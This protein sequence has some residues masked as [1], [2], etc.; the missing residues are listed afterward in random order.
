MDFQINVEL[1]N[2]SERVNLRKELRGYAV[3]VAFPF[4]IHHAI[5]ESLCHIA[6]ARNEGASIRL[7]LFWS[8]LFATLT[9]SLTC[10]SP[11]STLTLCIVQLHYRHKSFPKFGK[12]G[13]CKPRA[14]YSSVMKA[15]CAINPQ[16]A[17]G[18]QLP[19]NRKALGVRNVLPSSQLYI[20]QLCVTHPSPQGLNDR[21]FGEN[22]H[23]QNDGLFYF[24]L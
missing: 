21:K 12:L 19:P 7:S 4:C 8:L 2:I 5:V 18:D 22:L 16:S 1:K 15:V 17:L 6:S 11:A 10:L 14:G 9:T 20:S 3:V 13:I 24:V 23:F